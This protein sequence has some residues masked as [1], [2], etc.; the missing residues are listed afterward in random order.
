MQSLRIDLD[1][2][3]A[4]LRERNPQVESWLDRAT[5]DIYQL[6]ALFGD[7][8][9]EDDPAFVAAMTQTP[10]RF[11]RLPNVPAAVGFAAMREFHASVT[12]AALHAAL[13]SALQRQRAFFH[14]QDVLA[15]VS[16][17]QARWQQWN[18][19]CTLNWADDWLRQQGLRRRDD[20]GT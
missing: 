15:A 4:A 13:A 12:D 11:L 14:F 8:E 1:D 20:S 5:G 6:S 17:E 16:V 10:T 18:R 3:L 19:Q 7:D 2:L 9:V